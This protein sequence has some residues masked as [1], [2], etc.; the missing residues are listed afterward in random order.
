[1]TDK[2]N[3]IK[4]NKIEDQ[5][6]TIKKEKKAIHRIKI[7]NKILISY[8]QNISQFS[9]MELLHQ[10]IHELVILKDTDRIYLKKLLAIQRA[11]PHQQ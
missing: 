5:K 4:R 10:H 1:M 8:I 2:L 6:T 7:T 9:R 3:Y 11:H